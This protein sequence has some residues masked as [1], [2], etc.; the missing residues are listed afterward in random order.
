MKNVED[1]AFTAGGGF[2]VV[3]ANNF[4]E[5]MNAPHLF[6]TAMRQELKP[7]GLL[8]LGVPVIPYF[9]WLMIFRQFRGSYA[10]SHVN[11]FTRRTLIATVRAA[12]WHVRAARPF[13]FQMAGLDLFGNLIAPHIYVVAES[14]L[15]FKYSRKRS[16]SL[17]GY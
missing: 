12:G 13:Y 8:I 9:S 3:W 6:L 14:D 1:P 7:N 15:N 4:F 5:H 11:F 16:L 2:D 17:A 10:S